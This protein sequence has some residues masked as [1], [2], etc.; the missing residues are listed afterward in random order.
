MRKS[1]VY[2]WRHR[3]AEHLARSIRWRRR[4]RKPPIKMNGKRDTLCVANE[5]LLRDVGLHN[6]AADQSDYRS[7]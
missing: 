4:E 7:T 5:H 3:I 6:G 2:G 1:H